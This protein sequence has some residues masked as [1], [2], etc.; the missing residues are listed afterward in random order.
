MALAS[1]MDSI[2]SE[3][4]WQSSMPSSQTTFHCQAS[5]DDLVAS[6]SPRALLALSQRWLVPAEGVLLLGPGASAMGEMA[7][8]ISSREASAISAVI[9]GAHLG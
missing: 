7:V 4:F 2:V 9:W 1:F 8:G 5:M 6:S 3:L